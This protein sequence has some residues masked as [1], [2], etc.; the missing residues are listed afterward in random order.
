[1]ASRPL[2]NCLACGNAGPIVYLD[3]GFQP[4]ANSYHR[5]EPLPTYPLEVAFCAHCSHSQLTVDV[6]PRE[7]FDHYLYVSGTSRTLRTHFQELAS[8]LLSRWKGPRPP[9]VLEIACNDGT[10]LEC[11][12]DAGADV[13]GIEPAENLVALCR[14]KGLPVERAYWS[15]DVAASLSSAFD[16]IVAIN[17]L[18]HVA[19]P[20]SF[21]TAC[22]TVLSPG[23]EICIQTSQCDM[24]AR[25]EFDAIYHEHR[26]YFTA[27]SF[28]TL[29]GRA[30]LT[31]V[32]ADKVDVHSKSLRF[33]LRT[34]LQQAEVTERLLAEERAE[35]VFSLDRYRRFAGAAGQ[36]LRC[37]K[38]WMEQSRLEGRRLVGYGAS[39]KGNTVLNAASV[40]LDYI[41]DDNPLKWGYLT[42]GRNIPI[43]PL[44]RLIEEPEPVDILLLAW[45][46]AD[47]ITER[48]RSVRRGGDRLVRYLPDVNVA[49]I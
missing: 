11:F 21:L 6:D 19:D 27:H 3:L 32:S 30:G 45:N 44:Q 2:T 43:V 13:L 49:N 24:F 23:G 5:G 29:A 16:M 36:S 33:H 20:L 42:P 12:R 22:R 47:E 39:A 48:L 37:L 34:D 26:S 40:D 35:E 38:S 28:L 31:A 17:V 25:G 4:L 41:V 18:P 46:F 9:R 14:D 1:M 8:L 10:L 15:A 7:M